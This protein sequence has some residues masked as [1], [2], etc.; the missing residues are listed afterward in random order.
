MSFM[1][2]SLVLAAVLATFGF[3]AGAEVIRCT[4]AAGNVSY[5]DGSCPH[6]ARKVASVTTTD[7]IAVVGGDRQP[8]PVRST[9]P[10][11]D[12]SVATAPPPTPA[13]PIIIDGRR[14]GNGAGGRSDDSRW[15]DRGE[16]PMWI[17]DGYYS[18]GVNRPPNRPRDMRPRITKCGDRTCKDVQGNHWDRTTGQLDRYRSIDGRTCRPV[19]TT[20]VCN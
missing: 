2:A 5:T 3:P 7:P 16:D 11:H 17:D 14:T 19:G 10:D 1:R 20:T 13:G 4:D 8:A 6:G 12:S 15:S 18:P 9:P